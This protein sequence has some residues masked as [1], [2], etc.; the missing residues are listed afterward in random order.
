MKNNKLLTLVKNFK[1][2]G[3]IISIK[4]FG[5]GHIN[6][7][8]DVLTSE[9]EY[10]LQEINNVAFKDVDILMNNINVVTNH[11]KSKGENTLDIV[12]SIDNKP[13][14][15]YENK[16]YRV[17][18]FIKNT[19]CYETVKEDPSLAFKLGVA[20]GRFHHL[21]SDLDS[22]LVKETIKDF[23]NTPER[24]LNFYSAFS[25]ASKEKKEG[26]SEEIDYIVS[27]KDT[28]SKIVDGIKNGSIKNHITHND[29]KINNILFDK[30]TKEVYA[31]I[32]LD[33][34]MPGSFLYD[35]G[36]AFR[37]L[38]TGENE[39]NPDLSLQKVDFEIFKQYMSAY[40]RE[41]KND[42]TQKEIELIPYSIYLLTIECGM[43]FLEDY[44]R[45]NV[46]FHVDYKEHNLVR[47]RTQIALAEDVLKNLDKLNKIVKDILE[48]NKMN[49][50]INEAQR[51][52]GEQYFSSLNIS[53][54]EVKDPSFL[55][56]KRKNNEV[57]ISY[58]QLSSLF[59]GLTLIKEKANET[60]YEVSFNRHFNSNCWMID[61]S[62]NATFK[63][64]QVKKVIMIMAL[65]GMNRL[66]LYTEDTY[67]MKKYP[68][69]GYLRGRYTKE[70]IQE[71]VEYGNSLGVELVPCIETLDHL[72]R[73][74]RWDAF[75]EV[76]DG[77]TNVMVENEKTYELVE[78]MIKTCREDYQS[79]YIHLGMDECWGLGLGRYKNLHGLPKDRIAL[80]NNHLR[81]VIDICHKYDFEPI[82]WGDMHF[83]LVNVN[84]DYYSDRDL[85]PEVKAMIP[86]DVG[87]IY[88]DYY[89]DNQKIYDDMVKKYLSLDNKVYFAGG[90]W[91][92][93]S[94]APFIQLAL[95]RSSFALTSMIEHKVKDI[96][97]T[98]WGD[99]GAECSNFTALPTLALYST[100]D[101]LG[102]NDEEA[103]KS[104]LYAVCE[105]KLENMFLL[106]TPNIVEDSVYPKET[107]CGRFYLYQDP[108]LGLFD[109]T[110]KPE[111]SK[112]YASYLPLI[113]KAQEES[114]Y[115][116]YLYKNTY[117]LLEL[118]SEKVDLGV[119]LRKA[120]QE[121]NNKELTQLR[122][123]DIPHII[124]LLDQ[125]K[126]SFK[127]R[128]DKENRS[129]GYEVMDGRLGFLRNRLET[130][131]EVVDKYL[132]HKIEKIDELEEEILP[133]STQV[134]DDELFVWKWDM[135]VTPGEL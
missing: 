82:I 47:C 2:A 60:N 9:N 14:V 54:Q 46:Y 93:A 17:Y 116:A 58:G 110:V 78:E 113:K 28:Y 101:Y 106:D 53:Y 87:I 127:E 34:V 44:L 79:K 117:D 96:M 62:R 86:K 111:Y 55:S 69:F 59:R 72:G 104:L 99:S 43:R 132:N 31:V 64:S 77:P 98:T 51:F 131:I 36:D 12:L 65:F 33:T 61:V 8:F 91:N 85:T 1:L 57:L 35:V 27:H 108:L 105:E 63:I 7:T 23:H 38:F 107:N 19:I 30:D 71:L 135:I 10:I 4:P 49:K 22:S 24:Y 26:A 102:H 29:P 118:L 90:A 129:F 56:V 16:Y 42:L 76:T 32:D 123:K 124:G 11:I 13:Y 68:Y 21:L 128:W 92:W 25:T 122:D 134:K 6:K 52:L 95:N 126:K 20:F 125:F 37:S 133:W 67:E 100:Y 18:R 115:Y 89:H 88:W 40:L 81:K 120:Y 84:G 80:F 75:L 70:D 74:L 114:K 73:T 50:M 39:D 94:F 119:R 48:E 41:M 15:E 97:V 121:K 3:K 5:N 83:R 112:K 103:L 109:K 130:T 66:M 45:G